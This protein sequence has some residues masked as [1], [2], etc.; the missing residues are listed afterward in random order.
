MVLSDSAIEDARSRT[1]K[2]AAQT[3]TGK[4]LIPFPFFR[5]ETTGNKTDD[6]TLII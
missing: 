5:T 1:G 6:M 2:Q 4:P 3:E